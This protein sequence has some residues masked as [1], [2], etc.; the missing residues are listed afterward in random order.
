[1]KPIKIKYFNDIIYNKEYLIIQTIKEI[2]IFIIINE[3]S[4]KKLYIY[5]EEGSISR[6]ISRFY[7]LLPI[8]DFNIFY[9]KNNKINYLIISFFYRTDCTS[10]SKRI[11]IVKFEKNNFILIKQVITCASE[12]YD[13]NLFLI[14]ED[15]DSKM[16]CL[17]YNSSHDLVLLKINDK[18]DIEQTNLKGLL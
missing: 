8:Y 11:S 3:T 12:F 4:Y 5:K 18:K 7:D 1:M 14:L 10:S 16:N 17:V 15:K 6:G 2:N 9:D 13:K